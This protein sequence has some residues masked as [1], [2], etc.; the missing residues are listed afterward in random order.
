MTHRI[1]TDSMGA[2]EVQ[3]QYYWGAQTQ[4]SLLYFNIG[5]DL[6]PIEVISAFGILKESCCYGQSRIR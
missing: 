4:R 3:A 2:V 1:E 6:M 5:K